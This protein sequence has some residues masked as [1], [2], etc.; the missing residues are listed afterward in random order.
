[1]VFEGTHAV[2]VVVSHNGSALQTVKARREVIVSAGVIG[3]AQ[4]LMLSGIGPRQ[5]LTDLKVSVV[6]VV[7]I[8]NSSAIDELSVSVCNGTLLCSICNI[9]R[10]TVEKCVE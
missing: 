1:V 6:S 5:H 10:N 4:L 8:V 3:S 7:N 9:H 2:G